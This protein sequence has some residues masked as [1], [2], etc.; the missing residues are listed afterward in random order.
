MVGSNAF[1]GSKFKDDMKKLM[2]ALNSTTP[3]FVRCIKPNALKKQQYVEPELLLHQLRYLGILDSI[4]IRHSGFSYRVPYATFYD[5]FIMVVPGG[6][7]LDGKQLPM[8]PRQSDDIKALCH[9]L[10]DVLWKMG[11][12][13][14]KFKQKS[15]YAV[16]TH[17]DF[18][19]SEAHPS[20]RLAS[21][22]ETSG[23]GCRSHETS[24][25]VPHALMQTRNE[26]LV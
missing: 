18:H 14:N 6:T 20:P 16:W 9:D 1:L 24:G 21:R 19:A 11:E 22:R 26:K 10:V 23:N 13:N 12:F 2:I 3:Q 25:S 4:R 17:K 7:A 5:R 8:R 15:G